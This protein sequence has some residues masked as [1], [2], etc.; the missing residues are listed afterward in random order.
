MN[1]SRTS[2]SPV[3]PLADLFG[4][5]DGFLSPSPVIPPR[6]VRM[7]ILL[8]DDDSP[9]AFYGLGGG[10]TVSKN[11]ETAYSLGDIFLQDVD[12]A[13]LRVDA[14]ADLVVSAMGHLEPVSWRI[15]SVL[16]HI[17]A[18]SWVLMCD[19]PISFGDLLHG[20]G[21]ASITDVSSRRRHHA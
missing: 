3:S 14:I 2:A 12:P 18:H 1:E 15:A 20:K 17:E 8:T 21:S 9:S 19:P 13:L 7:R 6:C 16:I 4:G 5:L 10:I 11:A